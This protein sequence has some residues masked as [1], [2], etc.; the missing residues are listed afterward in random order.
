MTIVVLFVG[1]ASSEVG[2]ETLCADDA[3]TSRGDDVASSFLWR[4]VA[5]V[6]C[7]SFLLIPFGVRVDKTRIHASSR[8]RRVL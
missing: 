8:R 2:R 4:G 1:A 5:M 3:M 7:Y 6:C